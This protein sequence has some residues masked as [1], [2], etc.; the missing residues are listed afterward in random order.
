M[1]KPGLKQ[2]NLFDLFL[3]LSVC[4]AGL[5]VYFTFIRPIEF[6]H[7]I[8]R[9]AVARYAE[10]EIFLPDD[11]SW[12]KDTLSVGEESR[13]VYGQLDWQILEIG[14]T[15][16]SGRKWVNIKA[17]LLVRKDDSGIVHYGRY[18]LVPGSWIYLINDR[19]VLDGRVFHFRLLEGEALS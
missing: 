19:Y 6:S 11:L 8:K 16:F 3:I 12:M 9:D 14:E 10:V 7:L 17:K 4:L 18:T 2:W 1:K 13:N 5:A 15:T